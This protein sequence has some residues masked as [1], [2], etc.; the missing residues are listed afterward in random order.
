MSLEHY[1][2]IPRVTCPC[3]WEHQHHLWPHGHT[4][5]W[6]N[7]GQARHLNCP[8][9]Q[10][11]VIIFDYCKALTGSPLLLTELSRREAWQ[12]ARPPAFNSLASFRSFYLFC[13]NDIRSLHLSSSQYSKAMSTEYLFNLSCYC[14]EL[15]DVASSSLSAPRLDLQLKISKCSVSLQQGRSIRSKVLGDNVAKNQ[16]SGD[17]V[18]AKGGTK[19]S[20]VVSSVGHINT[21]SMTKQSKRE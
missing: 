2:G 11:S 9:S 7:N 19:E 8:S 4:Q 12:H 18:S 17:K 1:F 3:Q 6:H 5:R 14:Q 20:Y 13:F 21:R 10:S 15:V 16:L